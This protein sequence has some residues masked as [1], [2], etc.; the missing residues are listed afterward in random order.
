MTGAVALVSLWSCVVSWD[1]RFEDPIPLPDGT[2]L[3]T[4][5]IGGSTSSRETSDQTAMDT[6]FY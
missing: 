2:Q 5:R 1:N 6:I 3:K 4:I